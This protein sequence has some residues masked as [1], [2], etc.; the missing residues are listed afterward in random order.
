LKQTLFIIVLV[1]L[2]QLQFPELSIAKPFSV[3]Q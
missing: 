1:V 2:S 3:G